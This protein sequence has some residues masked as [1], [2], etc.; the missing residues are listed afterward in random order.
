[1]SDAGYL[2][3]RLG[4]G[5]WALPDASVAAVRAIRSGVTVATRHGELVA[6]EVLGVAR[7]LAVRRPGAL[8]ARLW[9]QRC[10]GVAVHAGVPVVVIDPEA[11]PPE[12]R[13]KGASPHDQ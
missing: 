5:L 12:L 8:L 9:P 7:G 4:S 3:L 2:L 6:D 10:V 1:M 11:P 13:R